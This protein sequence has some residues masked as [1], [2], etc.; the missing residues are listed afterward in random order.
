MVADFN[1]KANRK[2][3]NEKLLFQILGIAFL[4]IAVVLVFAD[5]RIYQKKKELASKINDEQK[6]IEDIKK[7]SQNLRDEIAN[8]DNKDYLEKIAYEQLGQARPGETVYSFISPPE[9]TKPVQKPQN[10]WD[11]FTGWLSQSWSW[12]KSKF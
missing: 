3:F 1:K 10:F 4:L 8:S 5:V 7:S 2:F 9:K 6:Q 11:A 12:I